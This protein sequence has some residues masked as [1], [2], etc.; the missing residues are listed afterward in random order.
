MTGE[1]CVDADVPFVFT[2]SKVMPGW[3]PTQ[4]QRCFSPVEQDHLGVKACHDD[5]ER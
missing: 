1:A 2:C 3:M 4:I 5:G